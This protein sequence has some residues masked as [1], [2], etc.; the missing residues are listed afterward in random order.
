MDSPR[1]SRRKF[2]QTAAATGTASVLPSVDAKLLEQAAAQPN[3]IASA[4]EQVYRQKVL[5]TINGRE[6]T[7]DVDTRTTV[8]DLVREDL[9]M[10]GT[11]KGCDHGQCG[12]CTVLVNGRR[13]NS[14]MTLAVMHAGDEITTVEGLGGGDR[15]HPMQAAF[16]HTV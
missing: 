14:C 5:L 8:L 3:P 11:K 4:G 13:V 12:T 6:Q 16:V 2:L 10:P 7:V 1:W 15:L 9:A